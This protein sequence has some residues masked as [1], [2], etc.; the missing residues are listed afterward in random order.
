MRVLHINP[1]PPENLGGSEV[2]CK[3][4]SLQLT[5]Y[6][7]YKCDILTSDFFNRKIKKKKINNSVNVY[8]NKFLFNLWGKNPI[9]NIYN[10]LKKTIWR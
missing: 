7:D 2:F 4:L 6:T 5:K 3:N 1:Y 8:Y 9:V 10:F